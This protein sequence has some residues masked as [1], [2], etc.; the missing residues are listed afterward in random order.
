MGFDCHP[1]IELIEDRQY[2]VIIWDT[3]GN[4][5]YNSLKGL[6]YRSALGAIIVFDITNVKSFDSLTRWVEDV[7]QK[8]D[9]NVKIILIGN[10]KDKS[11][12]AEVEESLAEQ[13]A[14]EKNLCKYISTSALNNENIKEAFLFLLTEIIK[15]KKEDEGRSERSERSNTIKLEPRTTTQHKTVCNCS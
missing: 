6:Y 3:A 2:K 12:N 10:K 8:T 13:F 4:E 15:A 11:Y 5:R 1:K 7:K 9:G 14:K